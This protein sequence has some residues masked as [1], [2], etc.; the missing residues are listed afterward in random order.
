[1]A[2]LVHNPRRCPSAC[3]PSLAVHTR[4]ASGIRE[5]QD[6]NLRRISSPRSYHRP[7]VDEH[8]GQY[9]LRNV[10][11]QLILMRSDND[12]VVP[13]AQQL[14]QYCGMY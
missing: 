10:A 11:L 3:F 5:P 13:M 6:S 12:A 14:P 1:M 7:A 9:N 8:C 2:D 4:S